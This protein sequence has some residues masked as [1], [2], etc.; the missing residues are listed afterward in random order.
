MTKSG[1]NQWHG[2]ATEQ[3]WQQRINA[4]PY[5]SRQL[6]FKNINEAEARG[7]NA[8]AAK[9]RAEPRQPGGH[10]NNYAGTIGGPVVIP[11]IYN[12]KN[13]LFSFF[14]YNG[15]NDAKTEDPS[16]F[17]KTVPT[18]ANRAGDFS[19]LLQVDASRYQIYD[20]LTVRRDPDRS[21]HWIRDPMPG[22]IIPKSR[23]INPMY[24]SY[25][26]LYPIPNN[27][28]T[29]PRQEPRNNF[30]AVATPYNWQYKALQQRLDYNYSPAHRFFARWSW[31][32][33]F[34][35]RGDWTYSTLRGLNSNGLNRKNM[36]ATLDWTWTINSRTLL[37]V[38][39]AANEFTEGDR[40]PVPLKFKPTDVGLPKYLDEWAGDQHILPQVNVTGYTSSGPSGVPSY[41]RYRVYSLAANLSQI[42]GKHSLRGGVDT[43]QHFR[44]GG[45]GGNTSGNFGFNNSFTRRNDDS[46]VPP[47]DLGL[48]WAAFIMGLPNSMSVTAGNASY[49]SQSPYYGSY[50]Q[51]TWRLARNFTLNLGFRLEYEGGGTERYNR[52]IGYFDRNASVFVGKTAEEFYAANP[53]VQRDPA[54]FQVRGGTTFPGVDG[55]PRNAIQSQLMFMPRFA[56]AWQVNSKTVIRGGAGTFYD[57]LNVT[58][59]APNQTGFNRTTSTTVETNFGQNWLVGNPAEGISPLTD[60]F[61]LRSN[62]TRFDT[63]TNGQLGADTLAGRSYTFNDYETKRAHQHRWRLGIQRQFGKDSVF[64]ATYTGSYSQDVYVTI[65]LNPVPAEFWWNGNTRNSTL[66]SFLNGGVPNPFRLSNFPNLANENPALYADMFGQNFFRNTTLSRGQLLKPFPQMTGLSQ[67]M[68]PLGR[69]RTNGVELTFNRRFANGF[70]V[71]ATYTGTQ[72][73]AA[74][75][76]PNAY[77]RV[78]A[79]RE[80]NNSRPHR[81]TATSTYQIP[82]G[83]RRAFFKS[84]AM[85]KLLGGMQIAG[86]TEWQ[87]GPLLDW[88]NVYYYGNPDNIKLDSPGINQWINNAGTSCKDTPGP[89][90]GFERCAARAPDSFQTRVFPTRLSGVRKAH[91]MQTNVN[92]Q[93]E[94]PIYKERARLYLR[95]DMLNVFNRSQ[96]DGPSTDPLNTNFGRVTSQTSAINRF[97]QF[98]ARIQF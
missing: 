50:A 8:L 12:G 78:P 20:P 51:D 10:S 5:F 15:F 60:P 64:S 80:S 91:S 92:L 71:Y 38:A 30:L 36:G 77:D 90:S 83:R 93:R 84:G 63:S 35:D 37:D 44:T 75:W 1:T 9:L 25:A 46:F 22:N 68:A 28:P 82:F 97:L 3:H 59:N 56:F 7:N 62:G 52:M 43:R 81:I 98:Q 33:F 40:R 85:S 55:V 88:G 96:F 95:C 61:P 70:T 67:S 54:T 14:S 79:W 49:A 41:S 42:R 17:N 58:N 57:T 19:Q 27:D 2:T 21:E 53:I 18:L 66:A 89:D 26:K 72:A 87:P 76:F 39:A 74:D 48:G 16:N 24:D 86:T 73:R 13:K 47:G 4:T 65:D 32:N 34:E 6:Y 23:F 11:K 31:N 45:G 94:F 69:V 29:D